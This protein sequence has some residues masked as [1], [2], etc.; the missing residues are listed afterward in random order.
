M[1]DR[2]DL[3]VD[4]FRFLVDEFGFSVEKK[5]FDPC[6]M[7]NAFALFTSPKIGVE[8]AI[9]RNQVLVSLGD[10]TDPSEKWFEFSDVLKYYC[11]TET[12][13]IFYEKTEE[14]TWEQAIETQLS[15][16]AL[17]LR[18]DCQPFL[19]GDLS[20]KNEIKEI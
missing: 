4:H 9:D 14:N 2:D 12:A 15:R 1:K 10:R 16:V 11:P 17:L 20:M 7:G 6:M 19:N 18:T 3:I 8:I 5:V 13:Y